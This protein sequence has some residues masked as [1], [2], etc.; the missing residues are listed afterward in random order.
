M[1]FAELKAKA[2]GFSQSA[3]AKT[4]AYPSKSDSNKAVSSPTSSPNV[5]RSTQP[6]PSSNAQKTAPS[7]A[8]RCTVAQSTSSVSAGSNGGLPFSQLSTKDKQV[9]IGNFMS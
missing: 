1:D 3:A 5:T 2:E 6:L 4:K 7:V 8:P 9:R